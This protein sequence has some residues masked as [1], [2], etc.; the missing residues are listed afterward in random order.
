MRS[1]GKGLEGE[2][3][4]ERDREDYVDCMYNEWE[5]YYQCRIFEIVLNYYNYIML[6]I[7]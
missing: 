5:Q 3:P 1:L 6:C 7:N 4:L 2:G